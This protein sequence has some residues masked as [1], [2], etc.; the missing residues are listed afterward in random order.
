MDITEITR[1]AKIKGLTLVGTGDFTH[2][3]WFSE[4]SEEL[5]EVAGSSLYGSKKHPESPVFYMLTAEVCTIYT[6]DE[7]SKKI[8]HVI[9]TPSARNRHTNQ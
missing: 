3:K 5:T 1:F 6:V 2:P 4:L 7:K 8:H 9:F